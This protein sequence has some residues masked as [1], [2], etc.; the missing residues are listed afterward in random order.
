MIRTRL[1]IEISIVGRL[2]PARLAAPN[3]PDRG[4]HSKAHSPVTSVM[5]VVLRQFWCRRF[6]RRDPLS[7]AFRNEAMKRASRWHS[8]EFRGARQSWRSRCGRMT[9][10]KLKTHKPQI[11]PKRAHEPQA[12]PVTLMSRA[13]AC[14]IETS[15][16][17]RSARGGTAS[18][19]LKTT[20]RLGCNSPVGTSTAARFP[21]SNAA[22]CI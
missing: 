3:L 16:A 10:E 8:E 15:S 4:H 18:N 9:D 2:F 19:G 1:R 21:K 14:C 17:P 13:A 6:S 11:A 12:S 7:S 5:Q 22:W 20:S